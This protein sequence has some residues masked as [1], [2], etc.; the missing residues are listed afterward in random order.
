MNNLFDDFN[1]FVAGYANFVIL[2][3]GQYFSGGRLRIRYRPSAHFFS[4]I[5]IG[6]RRGIN[7]LID[8]YNF[9][10]YFCRSFLF[11]EI[12]ANH[13]RC[14]KQWATEKVA[15]NGQYRISNWW[16]SP[17]LL[18]W[19]LDSADITRPFTHAHTLRIDLWP[20]SKSGYRM[21]KLVFI[22]TRSK[23]FKNAL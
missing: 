10:R 4:A 5:L 12:S 16:N 20:K 2:R 6:N 7:Q 15:E 18:A 23:I 21:P 13:L 9:K 8:W 22:S 1:K 3:I 19:E 14:I 11:D 17:S